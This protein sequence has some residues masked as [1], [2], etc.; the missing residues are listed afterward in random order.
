MM[1][2]SITLLRDKVDNFTSIYVYIQQ[3]V[4]K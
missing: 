1:T 2:W 4:T 3:F